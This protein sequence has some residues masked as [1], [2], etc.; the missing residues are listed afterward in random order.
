M[1]D[2][3]EEFEREKQK[4]IEGWNKKE[5]P[6]STIILGMTALKREAR[7]RGIP[8]VVPKDIVLDLRRDVLKEMS[9]LDD[10]LVEG[11]PILY[12]PLFVILP[13]A[14]AE[15]VLAYGWRPTTNRPLLYLFKTE[16]GAK[17]NAELM[18]GEGLVLA[19]QDIPL[20]HLTALDALGRPIDM[21]LNLNEIFTNE[22]MEVAL[23]EEADAHYFSTLSEDMPEERID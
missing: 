2:F 20:D 1:L 13:K 11:A 21:E 8:F 10:D 3:A 7:L 5:I 4:L 17:K 18:A 19:L 9:V 14:E 16:S 22:E 23:S 12:E 6:S 15:L